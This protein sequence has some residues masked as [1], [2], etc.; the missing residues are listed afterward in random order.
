MK[1]VSRKGFT[2][3]EM[4]IAIV[5]VGII[6]GV[7]VAI[8][9]NPIGKASTGS[10][11]SKTADDL[12]L[13]ADAEDFYYAMNGEWASREDLLTSGALKAWPTPSVVVMDET[14]MNDRFAGC[15][16]SGTCGD[17]FTYDLWLEDMTDGDGYD[18][19]S[20]LVCVTEDFAIAFNER[21]LTD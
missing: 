11:V 20:A 9:G 17:H 13:I 3:L 18:F 14:C 6:V 15:Q 8:F 4:M 1:F 5:I 12:R 16:A 2:L 10:A 7:L 19:F 21:E